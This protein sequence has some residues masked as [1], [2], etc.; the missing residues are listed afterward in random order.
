MHASLTKNAIRLLLL[1]GFVSGTSASAA[2]TFSESL[3]GNSRP[4]GLSV[5]VAS[6]FG[7]VP[8]IAYTSGG[9]VFNNTG[10]ADRVFLKTDFNDYISYDFTAQ[11]TV[12]IPNNI[13]FFGIGQASSIVYPEPTNVIGT[14]SHSV[15]WGQQNG[16]L[17]GTT[18]S[19]L[20]AMNFSDH[21]SDIKLEWTAATKTAVFT[22]Y[23]YNASGDLVGTYTKTIDGSNNGL[24]AN[25]SYLYF[26]GAQGATVSSF[27]VV[28]E[29]SAF[30]AL[31]FGSILGLARRRRQRA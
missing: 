4:S 22:V 5:A 14:R 9:V 2:L 29:P 15:A 30:A 3:T 25:N 31:A 18:P 28:P 27:S 26:G 7:I 8:N 13:F 10:D 19:S 23:D 11:I 6:G 12:L 20:A 21:S 24:T 16:F 1:A 17:D